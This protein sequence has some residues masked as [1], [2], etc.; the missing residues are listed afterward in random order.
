M[1][2]NEPKQDVGHELKVRGS[3]TLQQRR[4]KSLKLYDCFGVAMALVN[5]PNVGLSRK[6]FIE[7]MVLLTREGR[8]H[9][10]F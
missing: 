4:R 3:E 9:T 6:V 10:S 2:L 8:G 5:D 1:A 7:K